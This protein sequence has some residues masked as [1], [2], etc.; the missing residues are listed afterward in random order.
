M[1][2]NALSRSRSRFPDG[3]RILKGKQE[4]V[5]YLENSTVRVWY[6]DTPQAYSS[7]F[8][9]AVEIIMPLRGEVEYTVSEFS[10]TVQADEV[11]IIPPGWEHSLTMGENS[12]RYLFLF[13]PDPIFGMRD[14]KLVEGILKIPIYLSGQPD[15]QETVRALLTQVVDIY[16]KRD[17]L[18]NSMC[19]SILTRI[20]VRL[21][22]MNMA[23][24]LGKSVSR[25]SHTDPEIIDSACVYIDNN[26]MRDIGL[27][28]LS[29][30]T[31]FT[32]C[33]FSRIFKQHTGITYSEYLRNKRVSVA[34]D[35]LIHSKLQIR[36]VATGAGFGS[37]ATFNRVFLDAKGCTPSKFRSIYADL[38][39]VR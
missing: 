11:L 33:Y 25:S 17:F 13:E 7:H 19:Y 38:D 28:D 21:G 26:Y 23:R 16:D 4:Y 15:L 1:D 37:I 10:Y 35:M 12:A 22:Q 20:Y 18:W 27:E 36:D 30:F 31:G 24:L 32:R 8:H 39:P 34:A 2:E 5:T 9:S 29:A 6:A 3:F 14:M